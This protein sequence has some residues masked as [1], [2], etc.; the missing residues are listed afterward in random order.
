MRAHYVI[1]LTNKYFLTI[2]FCVGGYMKK[3]RLL[4]L[5]VCL[6]ALTMLFA[7]V[8]PASAALTMQEQE[9]VYRVG[10]MWQADY[11]QDY[12]TWML[13]SDN[14]VYHL[15]CT[16]GYIFDYTLLM[17]NSVKKT[18]EYVKLLAAIIESVN[19]QLVD[20]AR[21]EVENA[22]ISEMSNS[23]AN[24]ALGVTGTYDIAKDVASTLNAIDLTKISDYRET[25]GDNSLEKLLTIYIIDM[26]GET[27]AESINNMFEAYKES[28][29]YVEFIEKFSG[30]AKTIS[31]AV[32]AGK[33]LTDLIVEAKAYTL[34]NEYN[35]QMVRYIHNATD[36]PALKAACQEVHIKI[37]LEYERNLALAIIDTCANTTATFFTRSAIDKIVSASSAA[38]KSAKLGYDIGVLVSKLLLNTDD[39]IAHMRSIYC[40]N[41]ISECIAHQLKADLSEMHLYEKEAEWFAEFAASMKYHV[42]TLIELRRLGELKYFKLKES[43]YASAIIATI[44]GISFGT[45]FNKPITTIDNWYIEFTEAMDTVDRHMF[46]EIATSLYYKGPSL[47]L[48]SSDGVLISYYGTRDRFSI[49]SF[50]SYIHTI[51]TYAFYQNEHIESVILGESVTSIESY[52]FTECENL[53][54]VTIENPEAVISDNAFVEC[55]EGF[56]L[57]GYEGST[58]EEYALKNGIPFFGVRNPYD[59]VIEYPEGLIVDYLDDDGLPTFVSGY[60]GNA[61]VLYIPYGMVGIASGAFEGNTSLT[62]VILPDTIEFISQDAFKDC[63]SLKSINV[64]SSVVYFDGGAFRG[65][66]ALETISVDE[67]NPLFT[68]IGGSVVR[69][70]DYSLVQ[71]CK[72]STLDASYGITAIEPYAF[73]DI[74]VSENLV[75]PSSIYSIGRNAFEGCTMLKSLTVRE[76]TC[77]IGESAFKGCSSLFEVSLPSSLESIGREAFSGCS[78]LKSLTIK[79]GVERINSQAFADCTSL[80]TVALP[81]SVTYI[82]S[83]VFKN[84]VNLNTL[85][86]PAAF[87]SF[88]SLFS[89]SNYPYIEELTIIGNEDIADKAFYLCHYVKNVTV[90]GNVKRVGAYAFNR[91]SSIVSVNIGDSVTSIGE[92]AFFDCILLDVLHIGNGIKHIPEYM[93]SSS[94]V[95][96]VTL[97]NSVESIGYAAFA[98]CTAITSIELPDTLKEIG[99]YAFYGCWA[100]SDLTLPEGLESI[101]IGAFDSCTALSSLILPE[102]VISFGDGAFRNMSDY[103]YNQY[104][105]GKY[106]G[107][108]TNPYLVLVSVTFNGDSFTA[109]DTTEYI[110]HRVFMDVMIR[111]IVLP[112][113]VKVIYDEAFYSCFTL[114]TVYYGADAESFGK[115]EIGEHND[116]LL[117]ATLVCH[118]H[119]YESYESVDNTTHRKYCECGE[120]IQGEHTP[121][122]L[123]VVNE[124]TCSSDGYAYIACVDCN[125]VIEE[126]VTPAAHSFSPEFTV[127]KSASCTENGEKSRHCLYCS[128]RTDVTVITAAHSFSTEFTVDKQ[129]SCT[130]N[131]EK[132]RHCLYCSERADVTVIT[133]AHSFNTEFTVDKSASCAEN[134][135]KSRHCLYCS[136]KT[137]VTV[138]AAAH[139]WSLDFTVDKAP[140]YTETGEESRHCTLCD[141]RT[142]ITAL[143]CLTLDGSKEDFK[144]SVYSDHIR[145]YE[146]IGTS[147]NLVISAFIDG[148][149]VTHID[150]FSFYENS[151]I[152]TAYIPYTVSNIEYY[153]FSDCENLESV[154]FSQG[155]TVLPNS[156]FNNC[157]SLTSVSLPT[158]LESI[159]KNAFYGCLSLTEIVIPEGVEIMGEEVFYDCEALESISFPSTLKRLG[160]NAVHN[161]AWFESLSDYATVV[162]DGVLVK[163][164]VDFG[165]DLHIPEGVKTISC[166]SYDTI[167]SSYLGTV[168]IPSTLTEWNQYALKLDVKE[169]VV[170]AQS[171]HFASVDGVMYTKDMKTIVAYPSRSSNGEYV[172]IEGIEMIADGAFYS[173]DFTKITLCDGLSVIGSRAFYFA[174]NMTKITLPNSITTIDEGAFMSCSALIDVILPAGISEIPTYAFFSCSALKT[175]TVYNGVTSIGSSAFYGCTN[176]E[177]I[178][179]VGTEEEWGN[180]EISSTNDILLSATV[181]FGDYIPHTHS[182][183]SVMPYDA[184]QHKFVCECGEYI[185]ASH[186]LVYVSCTEK[187]VC[188]LCAD[189][190]E[191][192]LGHS[193]TTYIPNNDAT[194]TEDGTKTAICDRCGQSDTVTDEG[195]ALGLARRFEDEI[196]LITVTGSADTYYAL[197]GAMLTYS[198]LSDEE[199]AEVS[200]KYE[201]LIGMIAEYNAMVDE[202]NE[203]VDEANELSLMPVYAIG[204]SLL[205]ALWLLI[206]KRLLA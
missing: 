172:L 36:D 197:Y 205:G 136:E 174:K 8:A 160:D 55:A 72:T 104:G 143:P 127:D 115:I 12:I 65:C 33:Y 117:S 198:M 76:G 132:S 46:Q 26:L 99:D 206:R 157:V 15:D 61:S 73:A 32:N 94:F 41:E 180:I 19:T 187:R 5:A 48:S 196:A 188:A 97:G 116:D 186:D 11:I 200:E 17:L 66:S 113:T 68:E 83:G 179:Y 4:R 100:L 175:V 96:D 80:E 138:I 10:T 150:A 88:D 178:N 1:I 155:L 13:N 58:A 191:E 111:E 81:E 123:T 159:G 37:H 145:I 56:T 50:Y 129:A 122:D 43:V 182:Y 34:A 18:D 202:V 153:A 86:T 140:T 90:A 102:S 82:D 141:A 148:L 204:F 142:D 38:F 192:A 169:Y 75:I 109:A 137:D 158:T 163:M 22:A 193:Y 91:A 25:L 165:A 135:E 112:K 166:I 130:E 101:G 30:I 60:E 27:K 131:G 87:S 134:G 120:Y 40:I 203:N 49:D 195:S 57:S 125:G 110:M 84:C 31:T 53:G 29:K 167:D 78:S 74:P 62:E 124:N 16:E 98:S 164:V 6:L 146:Y 28:T 21:L 7:A 20:V 79:N 128:E 103:V 85:T 52:A 139:V 69:R 95:Y 201:T 184:K 147:E 93:V 118:E 67:N 35:A 181:V 54:Y 108:A 170:D 92:Y 194:Y 156:M 51:G 14:F 151:L 144:Y 119:T 133:A 177:Q 161:T 71:G 47:D 149:P 63:T 106:I 152:K 89:K 23:F 107:T 9:D 59:T 2:S 3:K 24:F 185:L 168:Y 173:A 45:I 162:G 126:V 183:V 171:A 190:E 44:H 77:Y 114:E 70:E 121:G 105:D 176:L 64:P 154:I 199:K 42:K 189:S 39:T